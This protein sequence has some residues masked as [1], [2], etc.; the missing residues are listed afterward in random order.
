MAAIAEHDAAHATSATD[1]TGANRMEERILDA[2]IACVAVQGVR[3]T[4]VDDVAHAAG[5]SRA[6]VYRTFPGGRS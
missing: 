1:A 6:T 3:A 2:A 4:T 5:C